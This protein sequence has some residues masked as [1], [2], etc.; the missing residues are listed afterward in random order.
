MNNF[1]QVFT[2]FPKSIRT[3]SI[4]E[5]CC[6]HQIV[7]CCTIVLIFGGYALLQPYLAMNKKKWTKRTILDK[8]LPISQKVAELFPSPNIVVVIK[9]LILKE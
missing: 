8:F 5:H 6:C 1:G 9:S 2:Y 4:T 3:F 7:N